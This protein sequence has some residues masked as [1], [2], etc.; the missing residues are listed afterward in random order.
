M[1]RTVFNQQCS[2][3]IVQMDI[4]SLSDCHAKIVL[5]ISF[6]HEIVRFPRQEL[7]HLFRVI[8]VHSTPPFGDWMLLHGSG[9][10]WFGEARR[11]SVCSNP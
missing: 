3:Y 11:S 7:C 5:A 2:Y 6:H 8:L 9:R 10:S 4:K 1:I